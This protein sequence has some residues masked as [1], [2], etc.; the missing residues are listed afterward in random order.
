MV[1]ARR[2]PCHRERRPGDRSQLVGRRAVAARRKGEPIP[3]P[4]P[5]EQGH[6]AASVTQHLT[7][8]LRRC[9]AAPHWPLLLLAVGYCLWVCWGFAKPEVAKVALAYPGNLCS[10]SF[11]ALLVVTAR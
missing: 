9:L 3:A 1:A 11:L 6:P 2:L 7:R 8:W 4:S 5:T 10:G